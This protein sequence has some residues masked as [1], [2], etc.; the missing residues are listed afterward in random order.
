MSDKQR[1]CSQT[2]ECPGLWLLA[3]VELGIAGCITVA[4]AAGAS[5]GFVIVAFFAA[6]LIWLA[7]ASFSGPRRAVPQRATAGR[8][9]PQVAPRA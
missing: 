5:L 8:R 7:A 9:A 1:F 2:D 4:F 6:H 3:M